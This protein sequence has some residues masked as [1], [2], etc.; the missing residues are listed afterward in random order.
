MQI[1]FESIEY[2]LIYGSDIQRDGTYLEMNDMSGASPETILF[3]FFSD[4]TGRMTFSAYREDVPLDAVEWF[5]AQA[6]ERLSPTKASL[7]EDES[8]R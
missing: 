1:I 4:E 5:V 8:E 2:E 3:S 7:A 6:R